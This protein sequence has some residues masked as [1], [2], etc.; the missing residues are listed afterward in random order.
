MRQYSSQ[1]P[2]DFTIVHAPTSHYPCVSLAQ[3]FLSAN[4]TKLRRKMMY[5]A[6]K[7]CG[8]PD[9]DLLSLFFS[10]LMMLSVC[11]W[12]PRIEA[13][14]LQHLLTMDVPIIGV[15][16]LDGSGKEVPGAYIVADKSKIS[17]DKE[18]DLSD[19]NRSL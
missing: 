10:T 8:I 6:G 4:S 9:V 5:P 12:R 14:L 11:S 15:A 13:L 17:K 19:Q 1:N 7:G 3:P 16:A 18:K 2:L